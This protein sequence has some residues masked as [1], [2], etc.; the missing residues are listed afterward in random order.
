M[1]QTDGVGVV[2]CTGELFRWD[3]R[4]TRGPLP[5]VESE[6]KTALSWS[7]PIRAKKGQSS[8]MAAAAHVLVVGAVAYVAIRRSCAFALKTSCGNVCARGRRD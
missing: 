5:S 8:F 7:A 4:A 3:C 6:I 1:Y 2:P